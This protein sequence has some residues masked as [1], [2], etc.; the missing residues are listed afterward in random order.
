LSPNHLYDPRIGVDK[1]RVQRRAVL[2]ALSLHLP[3][4]DDSD[5][6]KPEGEGS[7]V[8][9]SRDLDRLS[10]TEIGVEYLIPGSA[11]FMIILVVQGAARKPT[12]QPRIVV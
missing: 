4:H 10:S 5:Q 6:G 8:R 3:L 1:D 12:L 2:L 11:V 7:I 9:D